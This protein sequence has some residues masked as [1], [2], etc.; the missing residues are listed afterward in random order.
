MQRKISRK[1]LLFV[2]LRNYFDRA[3][4]EQ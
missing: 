4:T 2:F 3:I 1:Y